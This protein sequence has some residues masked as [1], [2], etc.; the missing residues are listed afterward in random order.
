MLNA[1]RFH[2]VIT[3][4]IALA[5]SA[6]IFFP[7]NGLPDQV[8]SRR[9]PN[10]AEF[11][12]HQVGNDYRSFGIFPNY[13]SQVGVQDLGVVGPFST[14]GLAAFVHSIDPAGKLGFYGSTVLL[15]A[16][17]GADRYLQYRS[18]FDWL[19]VRFMV[20]ERS[21]FGRQPH[22]NEFHD[23][24]LREAGGVQESVFRRPG[25]S[26]RIAQRETAL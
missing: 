24:L 3:I 19:G 16:G 21:V 5:Y 15:L 10:F 25:G 6:I 4:V 13:S 8:Y 14:S 18:L 26:H 11:L 20:V 22:T 23:Y 12:K 7:E 9:L 1:K 2:I 17:V